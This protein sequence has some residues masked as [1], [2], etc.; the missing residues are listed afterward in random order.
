MSRELW[1]RKLRSRRVQCRLGRYIFFE[2]DIDG[3]KIVKIPL[4]GRIWTEK[5][6]KVGFEVEELPK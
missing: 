6:L 4:N 3:I 5:E 1:D 2:H